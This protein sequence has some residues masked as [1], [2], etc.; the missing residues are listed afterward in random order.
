MAQQ[1]IADEREVNTKRKRDKVAEQNAVTDLR[2]VMATKAGRAVMRRII[3]V[4]KLGEPT[5]FSPDP[6]FDAFV[7][8]GQNVGKWIVT[9]LRSHCMKE[10][11][12]MEDEDRVA[13]TIEA[14]EPEQ[15]T[16]DE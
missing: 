10:M 7:Q 9:E 8:G 11:R 5:T 1:N 14:V 16:K 2:A 4:T 15:E 12:L 13:A 3:A 6:R